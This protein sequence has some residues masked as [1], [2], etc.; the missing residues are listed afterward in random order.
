MF[1]KKKNAPM[2]TYD[3]TQAKENMVGWDNSCP[4][5]EVRAEETEGGNTQAKSR[6]CSFGQ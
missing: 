5:N 4:H 2:P 6:H 3:V 1:G